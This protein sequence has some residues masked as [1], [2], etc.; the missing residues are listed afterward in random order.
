MRE[1]VRVAFLAVRDGNSPDV[2]IADPQFNQ[3]FLRE[4]QSRGLSDPAPVLN[5]CL[6]NLRKTGDLRGVKSK[7]VTVRNQDEF[8]FASE[9]AIRFLERRDQRTL[10]QI[11]CDPDRAAEFDR[12]ASEI[13][14]GYSPFA[15]RWSALGLRKKRKL[16]PELLSKV[17][18]SEAVITGR[19]QDLNQ[20]DIPTQPGLY[21][22]IQP[23]SVLYVGECQNLRKRIRKHLDHSDSKGLAHWL[24]QRGM[25]DLHVEYHVLP[26]GV[27]AR[28]RKA[29]EAELIISR[30][31]LFNV[32]GVVDPR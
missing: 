24:W 3:A 2:V 21:L 18:P 12:I 22:F 11:L 8:R 1:T 27:A 23:G 25:T 5:Q 6:L 30:R 14:P 4:C 31:P 29:L 32:A 9:I 20:D 10:D 28:A 13:A 17:I 19:A 15:Y 26:A 7:R 16:R